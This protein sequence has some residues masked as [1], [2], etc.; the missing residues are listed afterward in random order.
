[1]RAVGWCGQWF[2]GVDFCALHQQ[3]PATASTLPDQRAPAMTCQQQATVDNRRRHQGTPLSVRQRQPMAANG[4]PHQRTASNSSQHQP[5][6]AVARP[7]PPAPTSGR[8]RTQAP[9]TIRQHPAEP[10]RTHPAQPV[11]ATLVS[12][13][14]RPVRVAAGRSGRSIFCVSTWALCWSR[15]VRCR[16]GS[17]PTSRRPPAG[18]P[19]GSGS[20]R[21]GESRWRNALAAA[22]SPS[23]HRIPARIVLRLN[24]VVFGAKARPP[25]KEEKTRIRNIAFSL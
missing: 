6:A 12:A 24:G 23:R 15:P 5:R 19:T 2:A 11:R 21:G 16:S 14:E 4:R 8:N 3:A 20:R 7:Y 9:A 22:S 18:F 25:E 13:A 1:M 10:S 17:R